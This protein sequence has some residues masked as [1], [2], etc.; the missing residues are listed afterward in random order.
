M[1][2]MSV[3]IEKLVSEHP[4]WKYANDAL[5][6]SWQVQDFSA[7]KPIISQLCEIAEDL[8]HHPTVTYGFNTV[9]L[10]TTTHDQGSVVTEKDIALA[11]RV[12]ALFN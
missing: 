12:S 2:H 5:T 8:D 1:E 3:Q 11:E 10:E 6:A 7:L 4:E 9:S